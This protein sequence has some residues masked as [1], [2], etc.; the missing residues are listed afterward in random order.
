MFGTSSLLLYLDHR[1]KSRQ[2]YCEF[3]KQ[4]MGPIFDVLGLEQGGVS[5]SDEYKLYNNEQLSSAQRSN[6]GVSIRNVT[7]SS[8]GL[9]DD[10]ILI[11][12]DI[13]HL[14]CLLYL[15]VQYCNK[16]EVELVP[17]KTKLLAFSNVNDKI[18]LNYVK[19]ISPISL[20]NERI[21]FSDEAEHVGILRST[22]GGNL[23]NI[24]ERISAH[25]KALSSVLPAGLALHHHANP[26]A[27]LHVEQL[28]ALPV[29]LSGLS[30]LVLSKY[31]INLI[32]SHYKNTLLRLMKLH[33]RTPDC[34]VFFL[35]GS[36][37][38]S[39]LLHLRQLS[40]FGMICRLDGNIL[41]TM[42]LKTL[43]EAKPAANSWFQQ[44]RDLCIQYQLPHPIALLETPP[45]KTRFKKLCELK[46]N[47][48][49][50]SKFTIESK[51]PSLKF[52]HPNFLSLTTTHPIWSSLNGNPYQTLKAKTQ[53]R[54]FS[55]RFRTESLCRFW[56][57]NKEGVCLLDS[58]RGLHITEDLEHIVVSCA[59]LTETRR[60][61]TRFTT[62]YI[63]DKPILKPLIAAYLCS[64]QDLFMQFII[65]C[66]ILPLVIASYQKYGP[67][68]YEHLF[69]ISRT[70]CY[71]LDCDRSKLLGRY[72][73]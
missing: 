18:F 21:E 39:A 14:Q 19:L 73:K 3:D 6:L 28:H 13:T 54:F 26:A 35:A 42:A 66:S 43:V 56:S 23:P 11:S 48:Y 38:G 64:T 53:A 41:K 50:H 33:E 63:A 15:T 49:W 1:L 51:L 60:R 65:D 71:S 69:H 72:R 9:A 30:A 8:I 57:D 46:V 31:E 7:I 61:L 17:E 24:V 2:T 70:W 40:L 67:T 44:I 34:V 37:P 16:Y 27:G 20:N 22:S 10:A 29:L 45:L 25:N 58:C 68:I 47:E 5:S 32:S 36:L 62:D 52:L 59:G 55:G 4:L 12:N